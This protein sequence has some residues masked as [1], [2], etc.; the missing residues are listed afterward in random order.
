MFVMTAVNL[1][2][3]VNVHLASANSTN[4]SFH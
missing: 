1:S 2:Y 4:M 3:L